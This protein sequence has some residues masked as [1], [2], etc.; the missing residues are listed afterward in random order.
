MGII[1]TI[2]DIPIEHAKNVFGQFDDF[3]KKI[4]KALNVTIVVRDGEVK[5]LGNEVY[6]CPGYL[7]VGGLEKEC[8]DSN[9]RFF[10]FDRII[11]TWKY[12]T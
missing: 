9:K 4:E 12:H 5:I 7:N 11:K 2:V 8:Q 10:T 1:E 6:D 3:L